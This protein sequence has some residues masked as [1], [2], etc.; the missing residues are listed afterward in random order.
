MI[1]HEMGNFVIWPLLDD[2][3]TQ[4]DETAMKPYWLRPSREKLAAMGLLG[5]NALW[6]AMSAKLFLFCW[7]NQVEA[8]R[9]TSL[10]SGYEW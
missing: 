5:E 1:V 10:I 2:S 8:V 9:K 6:S 4:F 3:I 7:K